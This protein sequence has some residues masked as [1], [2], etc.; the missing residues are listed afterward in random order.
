MK[1][2]VPTSQGKLAAHFGHCDSFTLVEVNQD[3][4]EVQGTETLESPPH[5]PG[6]LPSWLWQ[7]GATVIL[8]GGMGT[9]AQEL[10]TRAGIEVVV[11]CPVEHP[12]SL[13][14][15]YLAGSLQAGGN[16]CDH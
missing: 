7:R 9:R 3:S 11:G 5:Q 2:A 15:A 13:V 12:D 10:F 1:I 8:A 16:L 14:Q 6:M 4:R